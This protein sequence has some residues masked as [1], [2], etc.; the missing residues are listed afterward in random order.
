MITI[1]YPP[2]EVGG[3]EVYVAGLVEALRAHGCASEVAHIAE[4]PSG[5]DIAVQSEVRGSTLVHR[6]VVPRS[7]FHL[8]TVVFD[9]ALRDRIIAVFRRLIHDRRPDVIHLHPLQLGLE[10]YLLDALRSDGRTLV[11][12]YHSS[13][14]SCA[15]GDLVRF[16]RSAC[17]GVIRQIA[18]TE[19][20]MHARGVPRP[21]AAGLARLPLTWHRAGYQR[22][23]TGAL[24]KLRALCSFALVVEARRTCWARAIS[25]SDRVIAVCDWVK[26]LCLSNG[27]P[28]RKLVLSRHGHRFRTAR[29]AFAPSGAVRFGY[30]GRLSPEKGVHVL[31]EAVADI[32]R[33]VRFE[34]EFVSATLDSGT[35]APDEQRVIQQLRAAAAG[36]DRLRLRGAVADDRLTA[37][38]A[39]WDAMIVPSLWFESGP[40]VV[41]EAF[42]AAT[43]IIGSR[44]GGIAEL[45]SEGETGFLFEPGQAH[46]LATLLRRFAVDPAPLRALRSRIPP[47]RT[48]A[49]VAA[50]MIDV[51]RSL[52]KAHVAV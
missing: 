2:T 25:A 22:T 40:Q 5:E 15:R 37:T 36:D 17:D 35:P 44:R 29:A 50:D 39:T 45:V 33:N 8:E 19:C 14:T 4:T 52:V 32:S 13:T 21:L 28:A 27:V 6:I 26:A 23:Q 41:Y 18:C 38:I 1:G 46:S 31:L 20:L 9:E 24:K 42:A 10:A 34:I 47:V 16:G 49:D 48:T 7:R 3:T 12:T 30:L 51:Y 43:P 11:L